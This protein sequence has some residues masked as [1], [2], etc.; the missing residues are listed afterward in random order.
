[1]YFITAV[2]TSRKYSCY[3]KHLKVTV[4][5]GLNWLAVVSVFE[6]SILLNYSAHKQCR[7]LLKE[8]AKC[9]NNHCPNI[10]TSFTGYVTMI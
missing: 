7:R 4:Q 9:F 2:Y 6:F 8:G 3:A 1:M 5:T 10:R